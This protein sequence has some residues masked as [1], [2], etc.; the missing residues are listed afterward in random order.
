MDDF[1]YV[2]SLNFH[3]HFCHCRSQWNWTW[4]SFFDVGDLLAIFSPS[5]LG[6]GSKLF[7]ILTDLVFVFSFNDFTAFAL[8]FSSL[9]FSFIIWCVDLQSFSQSWLL[10]IIFFHFTYK[11]YFDIILKCNIYVNYIFVTMNYIYVISPL[12]LC[13][14]CIS[15]LCIVIL[16]ACHA[17]N[18]VSSNSP[19]A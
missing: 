11:L 4:T 2:L 6:C 19:T 1:V 17:T 14:S 16:F 7:A 5:V 3:H 18:L 10:Q 8:F 12:R 13:T 9:F 15:F